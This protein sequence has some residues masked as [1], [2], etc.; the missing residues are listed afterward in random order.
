ME[1]RLEAVKRLSENEFDN[2]LIWN[3]VNLVL[4]KYIK[5]GDK[6]YKNGDVYICFH[7]T[8]KCLYGYKIKYNELPFIKCFEWKV[9]HPVTNL[10][11]TIAKYKYYYL[12]YD[13]NDPNSKCFRDEVVRFRYY[14]DNLFYKVDNHCIIVEED[15]NYSHY[16]KFI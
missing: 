12:D 5:I 7:T 10:Y 11:I 13:I 14:D 15:K 1:E 2:I 16:D 9:K 4:P 6:F 8:K 3:K